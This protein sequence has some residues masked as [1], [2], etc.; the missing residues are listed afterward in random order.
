M[1]INKMVLPKFKTAKEFRCAFPDAPRGAWKRDTMSVDMQA[2]LC[3]MHGIPVR[4]VCL[5]GAGYHNFLTESGKI[6]SAASREEFAR[7]TIAERK[8]TMSDDARAVRQK[9]GKKSGFVRKKK[10]TKNEPC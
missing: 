2:E 7:Q 5:S 4:I 10:E 1:N 8:Y 9:A 3:R 6:D